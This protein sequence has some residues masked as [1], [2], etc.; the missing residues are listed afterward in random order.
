MRIL[1]VE[2]ATQR[3]S[4]AVLEDTV[5]LAVIERASGG[6]QTEWLIP[7][8]AQL[9]SNVKLQLTDLDGLALSIG[10]GSFTGLRV[11]LATMLGFRQVTNLPLAGVPT[12]EGLAWN[13]RGA[14]QTVCPIV[15]AQKDHV[16]WACFRW[17][18]DKL[19]RLTEDRC[20]TVW[21]IPRSL[22]EPT[23][24]YGDGWLTHRATLMPQLLHDRTHLEGPSDSM[25][26]SA[27]SIGLAGLARLKRGEVIPQGMAPRYIQRSYAESAWDDK[28]TSGSKKT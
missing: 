13:L 21:E 20:G 11:G 14:V 28:E 8:I 26:P 9:L 25:Y 12:L 27:V 22:R 16:Y 1:A 7:A 6:S 10:P 15:G 3:Q 17:E 2:T 19:V 5:P 24:V 23:I 4:I 18:A